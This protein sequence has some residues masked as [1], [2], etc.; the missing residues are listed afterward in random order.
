MRCLP[1]RRRTH[2]RQTTDVAQVLLARRLRSSCASRFKWPQFRN[3]HFMLMALAGV[4]RMSCVVHVRSSVA[5]YRHDTTTAAAS[6]VI[7]SHTHTC[8]RM[9]RCAHRSVNPHTHTHECHSMCVPVVCG[10]C[11]DHRLIAFSSSYKR[12]PIANAVR[13]KT[14]ENVRDAFH[15]LEDQSIG[16]CSRI[17]EV[18]S[19]D[20]QSLLVGP[21]MH[22]FTC[23]PAAL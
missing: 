19:I 21:H 3:D 9:A 12:C 8:T 14:V 23:V 7:Y 1:I 5:W 13:S 22:I 6:S 17:R 16:R 4:S 18:R 10:W 20:H 11:G 2:T 15:Q